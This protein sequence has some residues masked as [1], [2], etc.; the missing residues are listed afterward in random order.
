M[1]LD[2]TPRLQLILDLIDSAAQ[3]V[4]LFAP[5]KS[6]V[7]AFSVMLTKNKSLMPW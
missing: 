3:K 4:I 7:A 1:H 6:A 5:F 2:N